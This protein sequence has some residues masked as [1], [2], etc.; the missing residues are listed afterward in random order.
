MTAIEGSFR[1][2]TAAAA[3]IGL[4][5]LAVAGTASAA[6]VPIANPGF[7]APGLAD[8]QF[9]N[10][11]V[12]DWDVTFGG[13]TR[14]GV[15]N[16]F[17]ADFANNIPPLGPDDQVAY[18]NEA[19][20]MT[21]NVG[22]ILGG[23][24]YVLGYDVGDRLGLSATGGANPPFPDIAFADITV[25]GGPTFSQALA[26]PADGTLE[27]QT[28]TLLAADLAAFIGSDLIIGFRNV[29]APANGQVLLDNITLDAMS[30]DPGPG[31][32][33][34]LPAGLPLLLTG[35]GALALVR[36]RA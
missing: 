2:T 5:A 33:V 25:D 30:P 19:G 1:F 15:Y 12:P 35:L 22:A 9:T 26:A 11:S 7:D 10:N 16:P 6:P 29:F 18:L 28:F 36:R 31:T 20:G 34:P 17:A 4:A 8:S 14:V 24:D 13:G 21:Q 32:V 3:A 27:R 23:M